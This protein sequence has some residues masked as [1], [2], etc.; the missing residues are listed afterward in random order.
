MILKVSD[1]TMQKRQISKFFCL[2]FGLFLATSCSKNVQPTS[3]YTPNYEK[4]GQDRHDG[5]GFQFPEKYPIEVLKG[6]ELPAH[7]YEEMEK[8]SITDE[9]PLTKDQT[10]KTTMLKRG[11]DENQKRELMNKL[12]QR[13]QDLGASGLMKVNYKVFSS[14][15][16]S[17]YIISA[18]A[19]RYVLKPLGSNN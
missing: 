4:G 10:Y 9:L 2:S 14:A 7:S 17:G 13:A 3:Y 6:D 5:L 8:L 15:N 18:V 1:I 19:F 16:S 12:V 11:N